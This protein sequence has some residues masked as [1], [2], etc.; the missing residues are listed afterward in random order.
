MT[1]RSIVTPL[2]LLALALTLAPTAD[3]ASQTDVA[4]MLAVARAELGDG[5][6]DLTVEFAEPG[7][8]DD[9][10]EPDDD[11]AVGLGGGCEIVLD[12]GW[13]ADA[14]WTGACSSLEHEYGHAIGLTFPENADD[15]DHSPDPRS[16]MYYAVG[17]RS[18]GCERADPATRINVRI[19]RRDRRWRALERRCVRLE[20]RRGTRRAG[21]CWRA[22]DRFDAATGRLFARVR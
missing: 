12:S 16:V 19:V 22:A 14:T 4:A 3:A 13:W 1:T 15:P 6:P 8:L 18:A 10:D 9:A 20:R 5:C 7:S 17:P 2:V 11:G 21:R